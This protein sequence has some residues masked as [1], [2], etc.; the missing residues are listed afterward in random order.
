M[1]QE[2]GAFLSHEKL[3]ARLARFVLAFFQAVTAWVKAA[4]IGNVILGVL[5]PPSEL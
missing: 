1:H 3:R 4:E 2:D 5:S